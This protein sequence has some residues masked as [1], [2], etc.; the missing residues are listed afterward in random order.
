MCLAAWPTW[1]AVL[2]NSTCCCCAFDLAEEIA[3]L[4]PVIVIHP[5]IP[6]GGRAVNLERRL[7]ELRLVYPFA[8]A[9]G[10]VGRRCPEIAVG[11]H[12]AVP[13]IAVEWTFR[14]VDGNVVVVDTE[15]IALR[16]SVRDNR[17]AAF[18]GR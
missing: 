14:R 18:V 12:G 5:V 2:S 4:L 16:V 9:I 7:I 1:R 10:E 11:A 6:M 13:M 8:A 15:A 17:P 3:R